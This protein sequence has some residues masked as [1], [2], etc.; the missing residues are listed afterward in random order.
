MS[1]SCSGQMGR[2]Q[3]G[4]GSLTAAARPGT[5]GNNLH[6]LSLIVWPV[7]GVML[8]PAGHRAR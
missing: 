4:L 6:F 2:L 8:Q 3:L 5:L 1:V 7:W